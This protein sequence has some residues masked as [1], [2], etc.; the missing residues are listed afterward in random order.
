MGMVNITPAPTPVPEEVVAKFAAEREEIRRK[1]GVRV[2]TK[3]EEGESVRYIRGGVYG[4]T[5]APQTTECGLFAKHTFLSFEVH[6]LGDNSVKLIVAMTGEMK[7]KVETESSLAEI[8]FYP[9]PYGTAHEC[10]V[11]AYETL[12][13]VKPPVKDEGNRIKA[14]YQPA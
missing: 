1:H 4:F 7:K 11:L 14:F 5:Y 2:V 12:R 13:H 3:E 6:T 9:E 8:E 10:M